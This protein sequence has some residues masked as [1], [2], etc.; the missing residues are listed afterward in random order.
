LKNILTKIQ[1][2]DTSYLL[3]QG[4]K[5]SNLLASHISRPEDTERTATVF[6]FLKD[7]MEFFKCC[8]PKVVTPTAR[9]FSIVTPA[10]CSLDSQQLMSMQSTSIMSHKGFI[11]ES[12]PQHLNAMVSPLTLSSE[13]GSS[14]NQTSARSLPALSIGL[15]EQG[16][17]HFVFF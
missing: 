6:Q 12:S 8:S 3:K 2:P 10:L 5:T 9:G 14:T 15:V 7:Y 13:T 17:G 16:Q 11:R 4:Q 1:H